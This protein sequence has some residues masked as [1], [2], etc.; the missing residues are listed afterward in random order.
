MIPLGNL[1]ATIINR[2]WDGATRDRQNNKV[3]SN[4]DAYEVEGCHLQQLTTD[5]TTQA[6]D[7]TDTLWVLFTPPLPAGRTIGPID[8][9]QIEAAAAHVEPD[10][11]GGF[12]TFEMEGHPDILHHIDGTV[13]HAE[14]IL[15]KVKL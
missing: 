8:R 14:L 2:G 3:V 11:S 6:R 15:R 7:S 13:H 12:A 10:Y 1:T 4:L 9:V 5:E